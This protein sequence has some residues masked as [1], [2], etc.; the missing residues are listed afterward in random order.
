M[1][2]ISIQS[3]R[4][5]WF[6]PPGASDKIGSHSTGHQD[7]EWNANHRIF[8]REIDEKTKYLEDEPDDRSRCTV[9]TTATAA[10]TSAVGLSSADTCRCLFRK[11]KKS[12][13]HANKNRRGKRPTND[14]RCGTRSFHFNSKRGM[15][16]NSFG[17]SPVAGRCCAS[18]TPRSRNPF[19]RVS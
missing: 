19:N 6:N 15:S 3:Q 13:R 2:L 1:A 12:Y 8:N 17:F 18:K 9:T 7:V 14:K 4:C 10:A 16:G 11:K 5:R